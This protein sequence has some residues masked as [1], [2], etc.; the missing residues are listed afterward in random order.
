[1]I[2]V[3]AG[4]IIK[5]EKILIAQRKQGS[6]LEYKWELP[7][8]KL[9]E[10][11]SPEECLKRELEEELNIEVEVKGLFTESEYSYPDLDVDILVFNMNYINGSFKLTSHSQVKWVK[12]SELGYY[13]FAEA[14]RPI[15]T[16]LMESYKCSTLG[17]NKDK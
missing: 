10:N 13:D 4:I 7:G 14:D 9:E 5:D 1:M 6:Y 11:E 16:K 3:A 2:L 15:V 8:G 17:S 12:P